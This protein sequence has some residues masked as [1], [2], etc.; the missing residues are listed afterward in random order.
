MKSI[1][2]CYMPAIVCHSASQLW[3]WFLLLLPLL[4]LLSLLLL[5]HPL[6]LQ[7]F[8]HEIIFPVANAWTP[9]HEWACSS[10][11]ALSGANCS[12]RGAC[13]LF[14]FLKLT[15]FIALEMTGI[16]NAHHK[17]WKACG[18]PLPASCSHHQRGL[19]EWKVRGIIL[20]LQSLTIPAVIDANCYGAKAP[21]HRGAGGSLCCAWD[22]YTN[23]LTILCTCLGVQRHRQ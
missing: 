13:F 12:Q 18:C 16:A 22:H 6:F 21:F 2:A 23:K 5:L 14:S 3:V 7:I 1:Q 20:H 15:E 10:M 17:H 8:Y 11:G 9:R 19:R 4:L